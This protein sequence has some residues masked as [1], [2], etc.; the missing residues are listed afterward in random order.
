MLNCETVRGIVAIGLILLMLAGL[1]ILVYHRIKREMGF[2]YRFIQTLAVVI[3]VPGILLLAVLGII[4]GETTAALIGA[5]M[6]YAFGL[7]AKEE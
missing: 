2:G 6:G 7:K 3:I 1:G 4:N 5:A